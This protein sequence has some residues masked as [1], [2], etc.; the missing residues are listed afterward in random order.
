MPTRLINK[1]IKNQNS[2]EGFTIVELL[3]AITIFALIM[4][5][6]SAGLIQVGRM[7]YR[8]VIVSRTQNTNRAL[9]DEVS[10]ALQFSGSRPTIVRDGS[11]QITRFCVGSAR[12]TVAIDDGIVGDDSD[13][14]STPYAVLRDPADPGCPL[15]DPTDPVQMS[16]TT[17]LLSD[18]M[19][20]TRFDVERVG[21]TDNYRIT[22]RV[23]YGEE[24]IVEDIDGDGQKV[25]RT[26]TIGVEFC[27]VS[28]LEATI[29]RRLT[30]E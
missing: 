27:A 2:E 16:A 25:C 8:T 28:N 15:M 20:L 22:S 18:N 4:T 10:R 9:I 7:Y 13:P 6:A 30:G 5:A 17:E 14:S 21:S 12:F 29:T 19:R 26:G 23:L 24:D 3:V 11:G 1:H